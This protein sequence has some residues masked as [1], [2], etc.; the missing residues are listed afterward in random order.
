MVELLITLTEIY[1]YSNLYKTK[2]IRLRDLSKKQINEITKILLEQRCQTPYWKF[3]ISYFLVAFH[4]K[5]LVQ[6]CSKF[7]FNAMKKIGYH[8]NEH[9]EHYIVPEDFNKAKQAENITGLL[10]M[11]SKH[12]RASRFF[13][14]I[15]HHPAR[16]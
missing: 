13:G 2:L 8:L 9:N 4:K 11:G 3:F 14:E 6:N 15:L 16:E 10:P 5:G 12:G 1:L 7:I